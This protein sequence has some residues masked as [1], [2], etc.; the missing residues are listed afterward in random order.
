LREFAGK[1]VKNEYYDDGQ[2]PEKSVDVE[3]AIKLKIENKAFLQY[4]ML[5]LYAQGE[6]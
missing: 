5:F 1:Y 3:L 2:A 6:V 4:V